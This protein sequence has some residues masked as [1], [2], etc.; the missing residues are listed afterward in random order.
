VSLNHKNPHADMLW[1]PNV[2][3]ELFVILRTQWDFS[4]INVNAYNKLHPLYEEFVTFLASSDG[5]IC[6]LHRG[7]QAVLNVK[8]FEAVAMH[9]V[10]SIVEEHGASSAY[11]NLNVPG[12]EGKIKFFLE[13][14]FMMKECLKNKCRSLIWNVIAVEINAREDGHKLLFSTSEFKYIYESDWLA[15][16]QTLYDQ[17]AREKL[18][19]EII[20]EESEEELESESSF[21]DNK[22]RSFLGGLDENGNVESLKFTYTLFSNF[23]TSPFQ[24]SPSL[25]TFTYVSGF[26]FLENRDEP[27]SMLSFFFVPP[28]H[29]M[30][31]LTYGPDVYPRTKIFNAQEYSDDSPEDGDSKSEFPQL[32]GVRRP[33]EKEDDEGSVEN[34]SRSNN[35]VATSPLLN[36]IS[37]LE[38][39]SNWSL[40]IDSLDFDSERVKGFKK[41]YILRRFMGELNMILHSGCILSY[42]GIVLADPNERREASGTF[43]S[44]SDHLEEADGND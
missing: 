15:E 37:F 10:Q 44:S 18:Q 19:F 25:D 41:D 32:R 11:D 4:Q 36:T 5:L 39:R 29:L 35:N 31:I 7:N 21:H 30:D 26:K 42:G 22:V 1:V 8:D 33:I 17:R 20:P 6:K 23:F 3:W 13:E 38:D 28:M 9:L 27:G 12:Y 24:H 2:I 16:L 14:D 40:Y 43:L 34:T